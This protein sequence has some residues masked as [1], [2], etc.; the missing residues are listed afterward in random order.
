MLGAVM[1][2]CVCRKT[3]L[4]PVTER[5][6]LAVVSVGAFIRRND[7]HDHDGAG[8]ACSICLQIAIARRLLNSL[9]CIVLAL[10]VFFAGRGKKPAGIQFFCFPPPL[11]L[12]LLK[13]QFNT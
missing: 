11:T 12:I 4:P 5:L 2:T 6:A 13:V 9:A 8:E 10:I 1:E 3:F 7:K